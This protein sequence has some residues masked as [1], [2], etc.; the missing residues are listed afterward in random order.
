MTLNK[1][2][3][4]NFILGIEKEL[5]PK[6]NDYYNL[7]TNLSSHSTVGSYIVI[8]RH[9][10]FKNSSSIQFDKSII[11][12]PEDLQR[13]IKNKIFDFIRGDSFKPILFVE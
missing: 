11:Y 4:T 8:V 2:D 12:L 13:E 3:W 6:L 10:K 5:Q 7:N 9:E 1:K